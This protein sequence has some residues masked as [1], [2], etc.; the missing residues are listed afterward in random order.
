M[1]PG[2]SIEAD[3][4]NAGRK[5]GSNGISGSLPGGRIPGAA[6]GR[7][8]WRRGQGSRTPSAR[9]QCSRR[10]IFAESDPIK[11][12]RSPDGSVNGM[13]ESG[14]ACRAPGLRRRSSP[15]RK[16]RNAGR[17]SWGSGVVRG[18]SRQIRQARIV[19]ASAS[20]S[21]RDS[22]AKVPS[23]GHRRICSNRPREITGPSGDAARSNRPPLACRQSV[24]LHTEPYGSVYAKPASMPRSPRSRTP[25]DAA[26][27]SSSGVQTLRS[28][29]L[30]TSST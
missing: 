13:P 9:W 8:H 3:S 25:P 2:V 24:C 18:R 30:P 21:G 28:R 22:T 16:T 12:R 29:S 15:C 11:R 19:A 23:A 14:R 4:Q 6:A 26:F 10:R 1:M 27:W 17:G 20:R 5:F 7:R